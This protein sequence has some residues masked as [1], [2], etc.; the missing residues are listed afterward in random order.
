VGTENDTQLPLFGTRHFFAASSSSLLRSSPCADGGDANS[1]PMIS[2]RNRAD[3]SWT[4]F[5]TSI[6]SPKKV[7][8]HLYRHQFK[9]ALSKL[10]GK[11]KVIK[12]LAF[13]EIMD[14]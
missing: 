3:S 12:P 5:V 7:C 2:K 6:S 10:C 1:E 8:Q 9:R 14:K 4:L 11:I 13:F